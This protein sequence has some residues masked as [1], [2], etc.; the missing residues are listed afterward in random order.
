MAGLTAEQQRFLDKYLQTAQDYQGQQISPY[1][2][3]PDVAYGSI[4]PSA[5]ITQ[6]ETAYNRISPDQGAVNAEMSALKQMEARGL[7]GMTPEDEADLFRAQMSANRS[8]R[9]RLGAIQNDMAS[10]GMRG[11]GLDAVMQL[12]AAQD[13]SEREALAAIE[14]AGQASNRRMQAQNTAAV[15]ASRMRGESFDEQSAKANAQDLISRFNANAQQ[16][17]QQRQM[18]AR[19]QAAQQNWA[20]RNQA[21]DQT[22]AARN[23]RQD[24]NIEV[25]QNANQ[26]GYNAATQAENRRLQEEAEKRRRNAAKWQAIGA[27]AGAGAGYAAGGDMKSAGQG[28]KIGE[29]SGA[30]ANPDNYGGGYAHGGIVKPINPMYPQADFSQSTIP[31]QDTGES[32]Y[33]QPLE[34]PPL[35]LPQAGPSARSSRDIVA[36]GG[37]VPPAPNQPQAPIP[38]DHPANDTVTIKA[39][40]GEGV[41][42]RSIMQEA[43]SGNDQAVLA[44]IKSMSTKD[45][46]LDQLKEN[47]KTMRDLSPFA[48]VANNFLAANRR[49]VIL[50]NPMQDLGKPEPVIQGYAPNIS[51]KDEVAQAKQDVA[52]RRGDIKDQQ[53]MD[54]QKAKLISGLGKQSA[55]T[56][57]AIAETEAIKTKTG[58]EQAE[59]DPTSRQSINASNIVRS[60]LAA[61]AKDAEAANRPE[62]ANEIR[63]YARNMKPMSAADAIEV[64]KWLDPLSFK[65]L[66]DNISAE[67][68]AQYMG[69]LNQE[70]FRNQQAQQDFANRLKLQEEQRNIQDQQLKIDKRNEDKQNVI[71]KQKQWDQ[72]YDQVKSAIEEL[73]NMSSQEALLPSAMGG[74]RELYNAKRAQLALK[75]TSLNSGARSDADF[76]NLIEPMLPSWSDTDKETRKLKGKQLNDTLIAERP[77][78]PEDNKPYEAGQATREIDQGQNTKLPPKV[79]SA[80]ANEAVV[81]D[82]KGKKWV[83]EVITKDG[84]LVTGKVLREYKENAK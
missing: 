1:E 54:F 20:R 33:I 32:T 35:D 39:S 31:Y 58:Q 19:N 59:Q 75:I 73:S 43:A 30:L 16:L 25:M 53:A 17:A 44:Y 51:F 52:D 47:Y 27:L 9:G 4:D 40:Q 67:K 57:K 68:R 66:L 77:I 3:G 11:S 10:R 22:T 28:A 18:D 61:L 37:V 71:N 34:L 48:D 26:M 5:V 72:S 41:I 24:R 55:E 14:A 79:E 78:L 7:T 50:H 2:V 83:V 65:D 64:R 62:Q 42:P 70:R 69:N 84:K 80:N 49:D 81:T 21:S 76:R 23:Q 46:E 38:G 74:K 15:M 60:K 45:P 8:N 29:A 36:S 12:Q 6:G 56:A 82:S 13:A 63:E